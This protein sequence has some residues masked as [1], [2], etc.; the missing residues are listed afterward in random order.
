MTDE[1]IF[2]TG[3]SGVGKSHMMAAIVTTIISIYCD[4]LIA[5]SY[6]QGKTRE[7][8]IEDGSYSILEQTVG[9][10]GIRWINVPE[11]LEEIKNGFRKDKQDRLDLKELASCEVLVLDDL[12]AEKTTDWTASTLYVLINK[13]IDNLKTTL[14]TSNISLE[15]FEDRDPRLASRLSSLRYHLLEGEDRR[16]S[17]A[18]S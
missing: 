5:G 6:N 12:G 14:I 16:D 9:R 17:F 3:L 10:C 4:V 2:I 15:G 8:A 1:G 7:E 11:L 18:K 13:R